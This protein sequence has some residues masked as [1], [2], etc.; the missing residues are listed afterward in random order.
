VKIQT[1]DR[2]ANPVLA[3]RVH[4]VRISDGNDCLGRRGDGAAGEAT[5]ATGSDL[6]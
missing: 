1:V 6:G 2:M 3:T 5:S 4:V